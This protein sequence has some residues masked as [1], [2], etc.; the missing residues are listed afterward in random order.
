M[1]LKR[2]VSHGGGL[3]WF[4]R[5]EAY[6]YVCANDPLNFW[7][8]TCI[9][10]YTLGTCFRC[11]YF[12]HAHYIVSAVLNNIPDKN[13][14]LL[15]RFIVVV[16]VYSMR[17]YFIAD[18]LLVYCVSSCRHRKK[19][20]PCYYYQKH[21]THDKQNKTKIMDTCRAILAN[22]KKKKK[23]KE[24]TTPTSVESHI[25]HVVKIAEQ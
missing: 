10:Y 17:S 3:E 7:R 14:S 4:Y 12:S 18:C 5:A 16:V 22:S 19:Y 15:L 25:N 9:Q 1:E 23:N 8:F 20:V 13:H 24:I 11:I 2:Q 6:I 21:N